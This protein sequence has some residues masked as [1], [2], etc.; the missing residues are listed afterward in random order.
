[1]SRFFKMKVRQ[2]TRN[3]STRSGHKRQGGAERNY[4]PSAMWTYVTKP[5]NMRQLHD[6]EQST[7]RDLQKAMQCGWSDFEKMRVSVLLVRP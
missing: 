3:R 7:M 4:N 5:F 1:M 6:P 2:D